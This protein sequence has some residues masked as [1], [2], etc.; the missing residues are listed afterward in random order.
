MTA[1]VLDEFKEILEA[2]VGGSRVNKGEG[3]RK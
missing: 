2:D 3:S 1:D